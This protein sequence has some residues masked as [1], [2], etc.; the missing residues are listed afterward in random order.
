MGRKTLLALTILT[1]LAGAL[2]AC[3]D[4]SD[5]PATAGETPQTM[6]SGDRP[7]P[8][9]SP[10]PDILLINRENPLPKDYDPGD[11]VNLY[12]RKDRHFQLARAD[13]EVCQAVFEAMDAMFAAAQEDGVD[14]FIITSGYRSPEKQS[15]VFEGTDDGTAAQPGESEHESGLAFDVTAKG[16]SNF[17]RTPQFKWLYKHC[18]EYGFILRYPKG[19]QEITGYPYESWHYRYVGLPH[20]KIIMD[21]GITLEEYL[22]V[23]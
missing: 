5:R 15:E 11:L 21:E 12:E 18:G 22:G 2:C 4:R 1:V 9:P 19:A 13:I 10:S 16:S 6:R 17:E 7:S 23:R 8:H 20:S 14:A 3:Q